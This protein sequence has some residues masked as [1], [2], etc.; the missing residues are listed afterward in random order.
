MKGLKKLGI[1]LGILAILVLLLYAVPKPK[2]DQ[3]NIWRK[4]ANDNQ[5]LVMAH[6]GGRGVY[7]DNTISGFTYSFN[8]GVDVL[9]MDVQMTKDGILV[10]RHGENVTGNIRSMSNCDTVVWDENYEDLYDSCNFGYNFQNEDGEYP[11]RD[12]TSAE[13]IAAGVYLTTLEELFQTFGDNILY[14]I[15][16]KADADAPRTETADA[17]Y[18]LLDQYDLLE[19]T[20]VATAFDDISQYIVNEYPEMQLSIS[21]AEA[22]RLII[23]AYTFT[24]VF[25]TPGQYAAVQIPTS[26]DIPVINTLNLATGLLVDTLHRHN[27]AVHYWTINDPDEMRRLIELGCDGIITDYPEVLMSV[28][29]EYSS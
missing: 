25:Y 6:A 10:L 2:Y 3:V 29:Q 15:E 8:L 27:M 4:E 12:M 19:E 5:V 24:S 18:A 28:I 9:E 17:L 23:P 21:Q 13:W 1:I 11:Y 26:F 16:I 14:N 22:Q 20:L 7:P